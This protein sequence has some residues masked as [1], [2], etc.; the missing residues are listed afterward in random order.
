MTTAREH[1]EA[2]GG[3]GASVLCP[4]S[5]RVRER[6]RGVSEGGGSVVALKRPA[7]T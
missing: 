6:G 1:E 5:E 3:D 2:R 7:Q 4:G